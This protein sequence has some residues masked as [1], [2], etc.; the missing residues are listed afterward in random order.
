MGKKS[1]FR[2]QINGICQGVPC[3]LSFFHLGC[4][5]TDRKQSPLLLA[6]ALHRVCVYICVFV[7]VGPCVCVSGSSVPTRTRQ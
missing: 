6:G 3:T 7:C 2:V 5:S 1:I 4:G